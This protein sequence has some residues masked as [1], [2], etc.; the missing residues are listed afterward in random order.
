MDAAE[1]RKAQETHLKALQSGQSSDGRS[2]GKRFKSTSS[3][4]VA[5]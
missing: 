5:V 1:R 3:L 2:M 4:H